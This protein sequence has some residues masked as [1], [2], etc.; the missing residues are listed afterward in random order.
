MKG[1][2]L[3]YPTSSTPLLE[4]GGL[5]KQQKFTLDT[6]ARRQFGVV[7]REFRIVANFDKMPTCEKFH[8]NG[9]FCA[10]VL[11]C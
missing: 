9:G 11:L 6:F 10:K 3:T 7:A 8:G 1:V 2:Q 4:S 5:E